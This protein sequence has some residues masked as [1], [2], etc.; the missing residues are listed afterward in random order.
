[1]ARDTLT[2]VALAVN[3]GTSGGSG[4]AINVTNGAAIPAGS[5]PRVILKVTN[6]YAGAKKVTV[7]AGANPP[8]FRANLGDLEVSLAQ[9]A[10]HYFVL[11]TARFAQADGSINVDYEASM[12]GTAWAFK[13]PVDL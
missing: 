2:P 9:N 4:V 1:M 10:T 5:M 13:L 3:A 8:A 12:T 6:T 7:K 11:E